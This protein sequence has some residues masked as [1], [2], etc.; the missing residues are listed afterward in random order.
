MR[1]CGKWRANLP[2]AV[3]ALTAGVL[4]AAGISDLLIV[5]EKLWVIY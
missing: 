1:A 3:L 2:S 5:Q 4:F